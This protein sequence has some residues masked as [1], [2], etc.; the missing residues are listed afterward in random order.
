MKRKYRL[1]E[2]ELIRLIKSVIREEKETVKHLTYTHPDPKEDDLDS[3]ICNI[4]IAKNRNTGEYSG[5]LV[6]S[7]FDKPTV[8]ATLPAA[9]K[10]RGDL[11]SF[12]CDHI[13]P[14]EGRKSVEQVLDDILSREETINENEL[15][16]SHDYFD[17]F[18]EP[19][20]CPA[21]KQVK[22]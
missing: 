16:F 1:T 11:E 10:D 21:K 12:I 7:K 8:I 13:V 4:Q 14:K 19:I 5:V 2:S 6:C 9:S 20:G 18:K 3:N 15:S 17:V 22:S